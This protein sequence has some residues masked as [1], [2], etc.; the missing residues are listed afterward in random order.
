MQRLL[1]GLR[2]FLSRTPRPALVVPKASRMKH[3]LLA[4]DGSKKANEALYLAAYLACS[5]GIKITVLTSLEKGIRE[6]LQ[7]QKAK[8]YLISQDVEAEYVT[9]R[10]TAGPIVVE[11]ARERG[12]DFVIMGGYSNPG[13][14]ELMWGSTLDYVLREFKGPVWV[15]S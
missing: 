4:Y 6:G 3:A 13:L 8:G 15:C 12:C 14:I 7:L 1:S 9:R 10:G 5:W 11:T 2:A